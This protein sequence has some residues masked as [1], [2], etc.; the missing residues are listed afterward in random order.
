M[1]SYKKE[2]RLGW[3]L[4]TWWAVIVRPIYFYTRLKEEDWK[5]KALTFFLINSWILGLA[6]TLMVF[7]I[8]YLPIGSTLIEGI[9]GLKFVLILPVLLTLAFVFFLITVLILGGMFAVIFFVLFCL[10]GILLHYVYLFLG[11]KGS[12]NRMLQ[13]MLY[14][15]AVILFG[16]TILFLMVLTGYGRLDFSLFRTGFDCIYFL[17]LLNIYGLWAVAGRKTY[18]VPRWKA[19]LGAIVPVIILLI[20]GFVFD[21]MALPKLQP[22][23]T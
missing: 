19:F 11:G 14:S 2:N 4:H 20:F 7:I 21:K 8:Q 6:A 10:A 3:F 5:E 1:I 22:W 13:S 15:S 9:S 18:G 17:I 16:M 23:I 12:L